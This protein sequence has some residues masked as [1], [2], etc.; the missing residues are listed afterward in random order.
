MTTRI[1][2]WGKITTKL[3]LSRLPFGYSIWQRLGLF[4]HGRM[5]NSKYAIGIFNNHTWKSGLSNNLCGKTLLELGPGDSI[6]TAI[7]ASAHGAR[8]LLVDTGEFVRS[9]IGPYLDLERMLIKQQLS[10][11]DLSD[12]PTINDI[13]ARCGAQYMTDGLSSLKQIESES[14]DLIFSQAV[15]EHVS[16]SE[17]FETMQEC[18]RILKPMGICS[19][20]VDLRDHLDGALNNLRFSERIWESG[21]FAKSGFYTNRIRFSQMM[22]LFDQAGFNIEVIDLHRWDKIPT[23]REKLNEDFRHLPDDDLSVSVFDVHLRRKS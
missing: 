6:A 13:L 23:P 12:C 20:Q 11:P 8:A 10:P 22:D 17:F 2:W 15:L 4:R 18:C 1:P 7:I 3:L 16:R 9:D 21:F 5:D 14:V 19:H